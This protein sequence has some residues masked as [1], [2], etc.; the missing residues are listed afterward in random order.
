L[1]LDEKHFYKIYND[2]T[3]KVLLLDRYHLARVRAPVPRR[4]T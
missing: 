3:G 4:V 2:D 1:Q